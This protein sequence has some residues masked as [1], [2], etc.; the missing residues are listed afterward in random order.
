MASAAD[1][2]VIDEAGQMSLAREHARRLSGPLGA[3]FWLGLAENGLDGLARGKPR[4]R[5][6]RLQA[7]ITA[8]R[9]RQ[10][11]RDL[12]PAGG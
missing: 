3:S 10:D 7:E 1:V 11:P 9:R 8:E 2:L 4:W 5:P 6:E 12:R